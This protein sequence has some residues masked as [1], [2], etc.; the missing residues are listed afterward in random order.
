[1]QRIALRFSTDNRGLPL[2]MLKLAAVCFVL[3]GV[4]ASRADAPAVNGIPEKFQAET[5]YENVAEIEFD[6]DEA[7]VTEPA[8]PPAEPLTP[9]ASTAAALAE[10]PVLWTNQLEFG[11]NGAAG[12]SRLFTA[13][14]GF[15]TKR[16]GK[17][18]DFKTSINYL[19]ATAND[20]ETQNQVFH[21]ARNE[22]KL[23]ESPWRYYVFENTTY[24]EF[25]AWK[26][27]LVMG[28]GFG[29]QFLK[30][31][32][33]SLQTRAGAGASREFRG[34][35]NEFVPEA[36]LG[37]DF[38][39]KLTQRQC[40]TS[41]VEYFPSFLGINDFRVNSKVAWE[42]AIDE[43]KNLSL[44]VGILDRYQSKADGRKPND[45]NYYT[46]LVWKF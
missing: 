29:Y 25:Q 42:C 39:H 2:A 11:M 22:W 8:S 20:E 40:L 19:K 7:A 33:T 44:R 13:R 16:E 21:D 26:V 45:I 28:S 43:A 18:T 27:R 36:N 12:N 4:T 5:F 1:M 15:A 30:N 9:D 24:D 31:D 3:S 14:A 38:E 32:R 6:P 10:K 46:E 23:G 37:F 34:P 41:S 17:K 35:R